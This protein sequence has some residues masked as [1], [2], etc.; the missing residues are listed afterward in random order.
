MSKKYTCICIDDDQIFVEIIK[1]FIKQIDWLE[2]IGAYSNPIEA[3]LAMDKQKPDILFLDLDMPNLTGYETLEAIDGALP[4]VIMISSHWEQEQEMLEA[5]AAK[6][7]K[8][9]IR[10][11][12][13]LEQIV[14]EVVNQTAA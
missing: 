7:V 8:K 13:Q 5:G 12:Q 10:N 6:Y 1:T 3:V 14:Q 11:A 4:K 9:P 2:L